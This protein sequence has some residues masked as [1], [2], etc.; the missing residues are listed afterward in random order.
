MPTAKT[1]EEQAHQSWINVSSTQA[2]ANTQVEVLYTAD[3]QRFDTC[4]L[5]WGLH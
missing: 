2:G 4:I 1:G 5:L 3:R